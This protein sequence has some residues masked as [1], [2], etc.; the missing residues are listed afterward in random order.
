MSPSGRR[1]DKEPNLLLSQ[2]L[3]T[4]DCPYRQKMFINAINIVRTFLA[5]HIQT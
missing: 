4:K 3:E 1:H 2:A 5:A